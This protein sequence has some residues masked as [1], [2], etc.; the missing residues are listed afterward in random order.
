MTFPSAWSSVPCI[1][2]LEV[3]YR[4]ENLEAKA[5]KGGSR[6]FALKN[7]MVVRKLPCYTS[8]AGWVGVR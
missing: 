3:E 1:A 8:E 5:D 2:A 4:A 6:I 7:E